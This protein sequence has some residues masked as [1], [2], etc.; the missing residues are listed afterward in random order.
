MQ[1]GVDGHISTVVFLICRCLTAVCSGG[2]T[3]AGEA[4]KA[5]II[6]RP[7]AS[8]LRQRNWL[9]SQVDWDTRWSLALASV[10]V[11][12]CALT[13]VVMSKGQ[14]HNKTALFLAKNNDGY[15]WQ[16]TPSSLWTV[17]F[18]E[19]PFVKR[20]CFHSKVCG[21]SPFTLSLCLNSVVVPVQCFKCFHTW[22][23]AKQIPLCSTL[24]YRAIGSTSELQQITMKISTWIKGQTNSK[25]SNSMIYLWCFWFFFYMDCCSTLLELPGQ[26]SV[27]FPSG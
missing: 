5:Q 12:V 3:S 21:T 11:C 23:S 16:S 1:L 10:S 13:H 25:R 6:I 18:T 15:S 24:Q 7:P 9:H 20:V 8:A 27:S 14:K 19:N 17:H 2:E 22:S 4:L 26:S